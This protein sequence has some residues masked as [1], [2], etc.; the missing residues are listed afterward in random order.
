MELPRADFLAYA[1]YDDKADLDL[2]ALDHVD[3]ASTPT[4]SRREP[5]T[6]ASSTITHNVSDQCV[7]DRIKKTIAVHSNRD[8]GIAKSRAVMGTENLEVS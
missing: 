6:Q 1:S 7:V 5:R 2:H 4:S 8:T 3:Q